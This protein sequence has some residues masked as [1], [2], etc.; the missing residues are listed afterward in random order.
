[1]LHLKNRS[2]TQ[3]YEQRQK[4]LTSEIDSEIDALSHCLL[5]NLLQPSPKCFLPNSQTIEVDI[6]QA[7]PSISF[8]A[9]NQKN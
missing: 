8:F 2:K 6:I 1:M 9:E 7:G 3:N 4:Y 5:F